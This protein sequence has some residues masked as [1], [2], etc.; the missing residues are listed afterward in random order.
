MRSS[1]AM[2]LGATAS[3]QACVW[4]SMIFKVVLL[5]GPVMGILL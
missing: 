2:A 4:M 5:G 1:D 3:G